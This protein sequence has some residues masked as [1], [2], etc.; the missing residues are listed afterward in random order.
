MI[1]N[2]RT[3]LG[4][5]LV[6]AAAQSRDEQALRALENRWTRA[7]IARDTVALNEILAD[8]FVLVWVDGSLV[9][10]PEILAGTAARRAEI[11]P[12]T[13]D[14]LEFRIF[15]EAAVATGKAVIKMRLAGQVEI[16]HFRYTEVFS[17]SASGWRAVSAQSTI[18]RPPRS[19]FESADASGNADDD[20]RH[21]VGGTPRQD[22][23]EEVIGGD[24][25][26]VRGELVKQF[27]ILDEAR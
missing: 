16:G 17:R 11:E 25:G 13:S 4:L 23:V 19:L 22:R 21:V 12:F 26:R 8:D 6:N 2:F 10:K 14:D 27:F 3:A 20:E 9:R 15:G 18:V 24:I 1:N 7:I 5:G